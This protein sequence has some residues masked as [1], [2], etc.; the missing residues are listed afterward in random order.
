MVN[1]GGIEPFSI[2]DFPGRLSAVI[3]TQGCNFRCP[4][5]Q[6]PELL[7]L[8][9]PT[10]ITHE[11]LF[12]FL[13]DRVGQLDGIVITGGE[14][15][16]QSDI[17]EFIRSI[18]E[19]GFKIKIDTNGSRPQVLGQLI[20]EGIIDYLA[21]D[22]K[23]PLEKYKLLTG[24]SVDTAS[25]KLSIELIL[26]SGKEYEFRTTVVKDLLEKPDLEKICDMING[27]DRYTVQNYRT[28]DKVGFSNTELKPFKEDQ[29]AEIEELLK[30]RFQKL[31]ILG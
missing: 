9:K 7:D 17:I 29:L 4:Y 5:C 20:K 12:K 11:E 23:A 25:V 22:I 6:N 30:D 26:S 18:K 28:P 13:E 16:N 31:S 21:M 8:N 19:M 14:P 15:T 3:F 10:S 1:I 24:K 27:A 2:S